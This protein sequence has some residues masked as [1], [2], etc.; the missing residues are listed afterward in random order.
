M[1][2]KTLIA[3]LFVLLCLL[4]GCSQ[5]IETTEEAPSNMLLGFS[6]LGSESSWRLGNTASIESAAKRHNISLMLENA[7]QKQEKQ[8]NAIRSFIAY[9]VDV[10]AFCPIVEDG[11]DNVLTEAKNANIPVILVDRLINT[12][13]D[14]LYTA[15]VGADF[16]QEGVNAADFLVRKAADMGKPQLNIVEI[17]GTEDATPTLQRYD[18]FHDVIDSDGRF[19]MLETISGD[20][21]R[22]K[23]EE[24]M[25]H[26][27]EKYGDAIDVMYSHNDSM[28]L[29]A[30]DAIEAWGAQPGKDIVIITVDGEQATI[31]L[32][33]EGKIN[34]V[35]ECT[36]MLGDIVMELTKKL[37]A[38]ETIPRVTYPI[39]Q[40]FS[41]YDDLSALPPR[42]Y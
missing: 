11:W 42:G 1:R 23:G 4:S 37:L 34:C 16:Y 14:T 13:D 39:E 6:Q 32:I 2:K 40:T 17:A 35:V 41:E 21:L 36:P 27:L 22:S 9:Q 26:L 5:K 20:F 18:G 24:C 15:Y 29:G 12:S 25:K 31:D 10:I 30:I 28:T 38:G 3:Y 8:I 7:N 33:A 19:H